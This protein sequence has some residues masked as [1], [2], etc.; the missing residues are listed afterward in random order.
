MMELVDLLTQEASEDEILAW[1]ESR[2]DGAEI[3][4][5]LLAQLFG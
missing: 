5:T 2:E 1:V 3:L 4:A